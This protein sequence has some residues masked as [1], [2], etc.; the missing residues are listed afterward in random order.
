MLSSLN[1]VVAYLNFFKLA[2]NIDIDG[3]NKKTKKKLPHAL[4]KAQQ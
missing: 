2:K 1:T 4:T 3:K